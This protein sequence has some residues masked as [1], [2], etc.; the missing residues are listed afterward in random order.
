[1]GK[2]V[3]GV[4]ASEVAEEEQLSDFAYCYLR[5]EGKIIRLDDNEREIDSFYL[6]N[7]IG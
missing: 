4:N 5:N 6:E 1:M 3:R 7:K 2:I